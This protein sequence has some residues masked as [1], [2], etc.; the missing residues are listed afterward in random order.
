MLSA[1][2]QADLSL[3][4]LDV[5]GCAAA[6]ARLVPYERFLR[7]RP[8]GAEATIWF[9]GQ[10]S[11]ASHAALANG[12]LAHHVEMDDGQTAASL[13][14]G[15][16]VIPA[17]LALGERVGANGRD[18]LTAIA[19]GYGAG[20]A[21]G[22][23]L[24]QGINDHNL[25]PPSMVG[26]LG[27]AAAAAKLLGLSAEQSASALGLVGTLMPL[28]PFESFTRG[29]T[30]KDL[31]GGWP[32]FVGIRAARFVEQGLSGP[33]EIF[34][35]ERDGVGTFLLHRA[36]EDR[37]V[38]DS[39]DWEEALDVYIKPFATCRAVQ[40]SLTALEKL[41]PL[42]VDAIQ[43]I[44]VA[45][46]GFAAELSRDSDA[47]TAIGAKTSIP[48]GI[49][50]LLL[51]GRVDPE[52]FVESALASAG[53]RQLAERVE[54]RSALEQGAKVTV[55]FRDGEQ[56]SA[57]A[58][59]ARS[60]SD[61]RAKFRRLAGAA[62]RAIEDAVDRLPD[63]GLEPL[64]AALRISPPHA[65]RAPRQPHP[66]P[67]ASA[68]SPLHRLASW[69]VDS[70][71][72]PF[73]A[74]HAARRLLV[75]QVGVS[76]AGALEI[77]L[78]PGEPE[79]TVWSSGLRAHAPDVVLQNRIAGDDLELH[80]GPEVAAAAV[81]ASEIAG[82]TLGE[83]LDAIAIAF[84]V[85]AYFRSWLQP[86]VERHGLHPP[87]LFGALSAAAASARLLGRNAE[88]FAGALASAAALAPQSPYVAF[89]RG[90]TGKWLYGAFSQRLGLECAL[91][92]PAGIAGPAS[93]F[94]GNRGIARA[95]L[96]GPSEA[97]TFAPEEW[98]VTKVT[99]KPYRSSRACHPALSAVEKLGP[100]DPDDIERVEVC[101]YPFAVE[102]E[103]RAR[104]RSHI[105]AQMSVRRA[106]ALLLARG[107]LDWNSLST[108]GV[109]ALEKRIRVSS[110]HAPAFPRTRR[111]E[112]R[113]TMKDGS[114]LVSE[115]DAKWSETN[116][117]TDEELR[118]RFLAAV[119][120]RQV[121]DPWE[122]PDDT[123]VS[124]LFG[125]RSSG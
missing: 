47:S 82:S 46:Y 11:S 35:S 85:E 5:L 89:S 83:L 42:D 76:L 112:V 95:L 115:S 105:A 91:W 65:P 2:A 39:L 123:R 21:C 114:L 14:G 90:V 109:A 8:L 3:L 71:E 28:G 34:S 120:G 72:V 53:R 50:T 36:I 94:E 116:P 99:F 106:V 48:Y 73:E 6:G 18:I 43:S 37:A 81:A 96:D 64:L 19:C 62:A 110:N 29:A 111:A 77:P 26:C 23:G 124:E 55:T 16:T 52:A 84:E 103:E 102:L 32:A 61:V 44:D 86:G 41:L 58:N 9:H 125:E 75:D 69:A 121:L 97:P 92:I 33:L 104:G 88:D 45:T 63:D 57:T 27:A 100:I 13:H 98:T 67:R 24:K 49:A 80:A 56:K 12:C 51:D 78:M 22:R 93:V 101:T 54:V 117:A 66:R 15:V 7:E 107:G 25:H 17:A 30:V 87:A 108:P 118:A 119:R 1:R 20:V 74:R 79:A 113:A 122:A 68:T 31:Y 38:L 10:R 59:E 70:Q 40:A 60:E 4:L